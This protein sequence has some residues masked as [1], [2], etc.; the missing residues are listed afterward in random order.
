MC[1]LRAQKWTIGT[2]LQGLNGRG[3][4]LLR[5]SMDA[6]TGRTDGPNLRIEIDLPVHLYGNLMS[7]KY[8]HWEAGRLFSFPGAPQRISLSSCS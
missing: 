8:L 1:I 2:V 4:N 3:I 7:G 6:L 5:T